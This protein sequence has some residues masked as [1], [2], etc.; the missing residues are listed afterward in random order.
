MN[1]K[2][3][4]HGWREE[5]GGGVSV[6]HC[7]SVFLVLWV[8]CTTVVH[9]F[10]SRSVPTVERRSEIHTSFPVVVVFF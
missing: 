6:H 9:Y 2:I 1:D 8:L 10:F 4:L 3:G 5:G 7:H